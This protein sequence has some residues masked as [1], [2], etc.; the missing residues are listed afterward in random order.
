MKK[1][2]SFAKNLQ[3][4]FCG[5]LQGRLI[6]V[7]IPSRGVGRIKELASSFKWWETSNWLA[8]QTCT[9]KPFLLCYL[10]S[11]NNDTVHSYSMHQLRSQS[12]LE[13]VEHS[14]LRLKC[15]IFGEIHNSCFAQGLAGNVKIYILHLSRMGIDQYAKGDV[16]CSQEKGLGHGCYSLWVTSLDPAR[17]AYTSLRLCTEQSHGAHED[18]AMSCHQMA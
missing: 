2:V 1:L 9:R 3:S 7:W 11:N 14:Y 17:Y 15:T 8:Q 18:L 4:G 16:L 12:A 5:F 6:K 10:Y 13:L